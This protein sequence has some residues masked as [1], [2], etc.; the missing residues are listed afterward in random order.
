MAADELR[1]YKVLQA[2]FEPFM[3]IPQ[4]GDRFLS[5]EGKE[6]TLLP[7]SFKT[8]EYWKDQLKD[9]IWFPLP[10]D[11]VNSERGLW[12]MI[13]W[14]RFIA[15]TQS[16][17]SLTILDEDTQESWNNNPSFSLLKALVVQNGIKI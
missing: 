4:W 1:L 14:E 8:N 5:P 3:G 6:Y 17:G 2:F 13:N 10:I 9:H 12:G 15:E 11:P 16:D 7:E